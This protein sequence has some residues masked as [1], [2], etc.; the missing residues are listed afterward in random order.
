[1]SRYAPHCRPTR[2]TQ[3]AAFCCQVAA[4]EVA[5]AL[6]DARACMDTAWPVCKRRAQA[7]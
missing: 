6:P 3:A 1:M 7:M 5:V 2:S 4:W